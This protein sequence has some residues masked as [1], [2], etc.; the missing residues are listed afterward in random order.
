[1]ATK[2]DALGYI[3]GVAEQGICTK[4]EVERAYDA[5]A[6]VR[7]GGD[8]VL[9]EKLGIAQILYYIG[10]GI[11]FLGI[12]I[13]VWQNWSSLSFVSRVLS[14]LGS[15]VAAYVAGLL[16]S[17][18]RRMEGV[19][20]A[21]HLIGA[22]VMPIGIWIVLE[23]A[24]FNA[25]SSGSQSLVSGIL[26]SMYLASFAL[27]R[28]N[29]F[30]L[31]GILFST[32]FYYAF[33]AW[34]FG[35]SLDWAT[36]IQYLTM[37]AGATYALLGY[38]FS[39]GERAPLSGFLYGFGV[40]GF[41]G[42]ALVLGGWKPNQNVFWELIYPALVFG[43]LFVSVHIKS[44]AFLTW[45]TLFLMAYILKITS[46]YFTTGLGWPLSLVLAGLSLI[47]V[48]YMSISIKKR[49]LEG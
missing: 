45:G 26:A 22:L 14:T 40:L 43:V 11:V 33:A 34:L 48:G 5:G 29:I 16:L 49:Y 32:W 42:A 30:T 46:E 37:A 28:K 10:G 2:E 8:V 1:M 41:L 44:K 18:D 20:S 31:F 12:S 19:G 27:F 13:L 24:G 6:S 3:R 35:V 7:Q 36:H 21:F 47:G 9:T 23:N 39:K 38:E 25:G 15:G 17:R 4:A